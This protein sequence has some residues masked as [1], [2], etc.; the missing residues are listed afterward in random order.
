M[1]NQ[2]EKATVGIFTTYS[3]NLKTA[4][5]F[6][7][8]II[9]VWNNPSDYPNKTDR[10]IDTGND[11]SIITVTAESSIMIAPTNNLRANTKLV[12][13][14]LNAQIG[15]VVTLTSVQPDQNVTSGQRI[16]ADHLNSIISVINQIQGVLSSYSGWFDANNKCA[17]SCQVACQ[18][19][20]Q[21][22]CQGCITEQ[23]HDQNCG[24]I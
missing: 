12:G 3:N 4:N 16:E 6:L 10:L 9:R 5:Q 1:P 13:D 22:A 21:V 24:G 2:Q 23:C 11:P 17:R 19:G 8:G 7:N 20:C 15:A 14:R 18:T